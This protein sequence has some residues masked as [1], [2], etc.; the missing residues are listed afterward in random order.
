MGRFL[1]SRPGTEAAGLVLFGAPLDLTG[2]GRRGAAAGPARVREVSSLLEEHSMD[3]GADLREVPFHD[4]GDLAL[5]PDPAGAVEAV[6]QWVRGLSALPLMLGGEHL[7]TLGVVRALARRHPELVV[8][9]LDAHADLRDR[10]EGQTLSHATVMRRVSEILAP[11]ALHQLG[12]RS[13]DREEV[14]FARAHSRLWPGP[15]PEAMERALAAAGE[16]PLYVTI[17][18]DVA[19]PAFAPGTGTPEPGGPSAAELLRAVRALRGMRVVGLDVVEICPAADRSDLTA[20]L[21]AKLVREAI[22]AVA[23]G[24]QA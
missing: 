20:L 12:V 15:L 22:L 4:A 16:R 13:A 7:A 11:G 19:D 1:A 21:G 9:Q 8:L 6:E 3:L 18:I 10:Y 5:P 23:E 24:E 17:D 14:D 2:C